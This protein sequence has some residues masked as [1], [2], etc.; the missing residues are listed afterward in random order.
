MR[1]GTATLSRVSAFA[2]VLSILISGT[3]LAFTSIQVPLKGRAAGAVV[4]VEPTPE[5]VLLTIHASGNST[6]L[7]DFHR[8]ERLLLDPDTG[9]FTGT[10]VFVAANSDELR[11]SVVGAFVSPTTA[12]GDYAFV[13]G[14]GRF[15][16]ASGGAS[17]EAVSPDGIQLAVGFTGTVSRVGN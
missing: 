14:T 8:V 15:A 6:Q 17:F 10:I 16:S 4:A 5:G 13:G 1:I 3:S 7:G 2:G 12:L 9:T 11:A